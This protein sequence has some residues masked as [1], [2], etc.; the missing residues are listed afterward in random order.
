MGVRPSR[1]SLSIGSEGPV[2]A[3]KNGRTTF[4]LASEARGVDVGP[5]PPGAHGTHIS[6]L[7]HVAGNAT[8]ATPDRAEPNAGD[9]Y[10]ASTILPASVP[11]P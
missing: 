11:A 6:G 7:G 5:R 2:S 8:Q 4:I 10:G 9:L 3:G 1:Q